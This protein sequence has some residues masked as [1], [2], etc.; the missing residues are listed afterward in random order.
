MQ[1]F[2]GIRLT[3][4]VVTDAGVPV[5]DAMVRAMSSSDPSFG[6]EARTDSNGSF[7]IEGAAP[8]HYNLAAAKS[9]YADGIL[10]DF[11]AS[12]G[13]PARIIMAVG[14][15][16]T[17]H[18][19]GLTDRELQQATVT[20]TTAGSGSTSTPV[21]ANGNYRIDGAP[22][23]T[24]RL[25]ART[26]QGLAAG[27][28][29]SPVKSIQVDP[30]ASVQ[31][32]LEFI[33]TVIRGRVTHNGQPV[34]SSV[35]HFM[36]RNA[37]AQTSANATTDSN[38]SYEVGGLDD[39]SYNV[40]VIDLQRTSPYNTTYDVH[41]SGSF[42]IDIK[43]APVR[44]SVI[45]ATTG[46]PIEGAQVLMQSA[47][48]EAFLTS[49][50]GQSNPSGVFVIDNV[51]QGS[52][53]V[54]AEKE[55]YGHDV[56]TIT[57]GDN[58]VD[59]VVFKLSPSSG[60]TLHVVDGRDQRPIGADVTRIVDGAG[61]EID[62]GSFRFG[63]G[64]EPIKLALSPGSYRVTLTSMGYAPRTVTITSPSEPT[65]A[66][67]PGGTVI[68]RSKSSTLLRARLVDS[69]GM[70]YTRGPFRNPIFT[71]DPSPGVTTLNNI[72]GGT[73]QLQILDGADRAINTIN[74]TVID[75][76]QVQVDV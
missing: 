20:A 69:N 28:K 64:P 30:G 40:Q 33:A 72:A 62:T 18:V 19:T 5:A 10:R 66:L 52:Y 1:L 76:Q 9:G 17:G 36:P 11:D 46:A 38:G 6:K 14:A 55:G 73:Y 47:V 42:D 74:V 41:G 61:R 53:Q 16:I 24:V 25:I 75:G 54:K 65:V 26:G 4:T 67:T 34:T 7:Q 51:A 35:V 22:S 58:G 39:A 70:P 68:L 56:Q 49:R 60:V 15:V 59:S 3:G 45:D 8:G 31:A 12:T 13:A 27:S 57:V 23:G 21:D 50:G 37:Q 44:G 2:S 71:I 29:T 43:A 63:G 48:G 32:D